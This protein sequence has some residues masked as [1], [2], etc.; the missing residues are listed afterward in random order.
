MLAQTQRKL[1]SFSLLRIAITDERTVTK[2]QQKY[3]RMQKYICGVKHG[4]AFTVIPLLQAK[5]HSRANF[6]D[7]PP[8]T[9]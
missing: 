2:C 5:A 8:S 4:M 1:A 9:V 3:L 7:V 6:S